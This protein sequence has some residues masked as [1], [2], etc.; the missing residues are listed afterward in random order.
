MVAPT[1]PNDKA[2]EQTAQSSVDDP[3]ATRT[4]E[5]ALGKVLVADNCVTQQ[6][7]RH[8]RR[9]QSKL[10][11]SKSL[12][13]VLQELSYIDRATLLKA[14]RKVPEK[15]RLGELL[16]EL[17]YLQETQ[18]RS[19]LSIQRDSP[20]KKQLGTVL[21]ENHFLSEDKLLDVLAVQL[22]V[23]R[24][25]P[26]FSKIDAQMLRNINPQWCREYNVVPVGVHRGKGVVATPAP[27]SDIVRQRARQV[28][29]SKT[30][31]ALCRRK[32][33][34]EAA[35]A[36]EKSL[37]RLKE[38]KSQ[39]GGSE[40][41]RMA[42]QILAEALVASASD[43]H[44]EPMAEHLRIRF[45]CDGVMI[46]HK[47]IESEL[48]DPLISRFKILAGA[49]ITEKRRHQD[50]RIVFEDPS[51]GQPVDLRASF[52][53]TIYG[54]KIVLRVLSSKVEML[55]VEE[56]GLP[57]RALDN[58][59]H[60]VL[61]TP[62]GII[63]ITGPTGSG[64]TTTLYSCINYLNSIERS[65]IT[66]EDPVEY[67]V[68]GI[69]Q[70][71]LNPKIDLTYNNTLPYMVRQDPDVI[72]LGEIR[73]N[74][75]ADAA[76]QA[77]L[78]GHKVLT[79]FHTEDTIGSLLRLMNMNIE[80]FL[81]SST[82]VSVLAQRLLRRVCPH[83]AEP[84][85]PSANELKRLGYNLSDLGDAQFMLGQGCDHCRFTGYKGRLG[86]YELLVLNEDVKDAILQNRSSYEIRRVS[87]ESSEM[88]TLLEDGLLKA[89]RGET[90]LSEVLRHLPRIEK[91]RPI[92]E[93]K[94]LTGTR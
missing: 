73:D 65:I 19:A 47:V 91:P 30:V 27:N 10:S 39:V 23:V 55:D 56:L 79:T 72:V 20:V 84:Y 68:E 5:D 82:V 58:F 60:D 8:A 71:S 6:Q 25:E 76:I 15:L 38:A 94:R 77:A 36:F 11:Q 51:T 33:I 74:F 66:A 3:N 59:Y 37:Q 75:S 2:D 45:R 41:V 22:G 53:V 32:S 49:D 87:F 9:V 50:G 88:T 24:V 62:S 78:T 18:L 46:P 13:V 34:E 26:D 29:G 85:Q 40:A 80:T 61:D 67:L 1:L 83:C 14:L 57:P 69:A 90:T 89:V 54:E 92:D 21:V 7:L 52:Y 86:V 63:L 12:A 93:I 43:V 4:F 28:F 17:G 31:F 70:C 16:V 35:N 48:V 42:D 44:I 81:I 64:K